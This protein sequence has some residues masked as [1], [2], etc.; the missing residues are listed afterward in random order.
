MKK[1]V[2]LLA[3]AISTFTLHSCKRNADPVVDSNEK[4]D[5][6]KPIS[7]GI[8]L[9][10]YQGGDINW[11]TVKC[12][13]HPIEFI[14]F[15]ATMGDDRKDK[16]Y[17]ERID[18]ARKA[19]FIVGAYHYYDP[20]ENSK[21]QARN[22]IS[23]VTLQGGDFIPVLDI[24]KLSRK[25]PRK[26]LLKGLKNWLAIVE[27]HYGVKP[28]IYTSQKFYEDYLEKD[29]SEYHLWVAAYSEHKREHP[30][31]KEAEV[32]QFTEE[33]RVS[34]ISGLVDGNDISRTKLDS[35]RIP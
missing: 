9:S 31:V 25:Q 13:K 10:E 34:G 5:S 28:M 17:A 33:V 12:C 23:T 18:G 21:K 15:R 3:I 8:D 22:Y 1:I 2:L 7:F 35:L 32:H 27:K 19:G 20:N 30:T 26:R 24:E 4:V 16:K 11:D 6:L 29:F 14:I